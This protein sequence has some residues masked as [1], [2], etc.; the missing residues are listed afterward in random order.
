VTCYWIILADLGQVAPT[1]YTP[2]ANP[3]FVRD[4]FTTALRHTAEYNIFVNSTLFELY[5]SYF[6][7]QIMPPS[8]LRPPSGAFAPLS[9]NNVLGPTPTTFKRSYGCYVRRWKS[10]LVAIFA[11]L[12]ATYA[13]VQGPYALFIFIAAWLEKRKEEKLYKLHNFGIG[14]SQNHRDIS[15]GKLFS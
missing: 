8:G 14:H 11:V 9:D 10:P 5:T 1:T 4:N 12:V 6:M 13:S 2:S 7:T 3:V 15:T